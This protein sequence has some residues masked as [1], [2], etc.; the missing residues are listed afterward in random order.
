MSQN[1]IS[2]AFEEVSNILDNLTDT[3]KLVDELI[4]SGMI[5]KDDTNL[6]NLLKSSDNITI[7]RDK[8]GSTKIKCKLSS[9]HAIEITVKK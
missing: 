1:F 3:S 4:D 8:K 2:M 6:I 9:K 7:N 5:P